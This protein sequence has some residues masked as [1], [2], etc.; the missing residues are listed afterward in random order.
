MNA[1]H[2]RSTAWRNERRSA[3]FFENRTTLVVVVRL[4]VAVIAAMKMAVT[5]TMT[6]VMSG[7]SG[8]PGSGTAA[9]VA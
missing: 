9:A 3:A 5:V 8:V 7:R 2:S 4:P 1:P 6:A